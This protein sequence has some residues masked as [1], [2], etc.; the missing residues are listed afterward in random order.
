MVQATGEKGSRASEAGGAASRERERVETEAAA[1]TGLLEQLRRSE[2]AGR[3]HVLIGPTSVLDPIV[4]NAASEA[5]ERLSA[6]VDIFRGD[7][8][9]KVT[10]EELRSAVDTAGACTATL[11]WLVDVQ[12]DGPDREQVDDAA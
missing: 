3:P 2:R 4:R 10:P 11:M 12:D 6:V 7:V 5:V 9:G 1:L 8:N